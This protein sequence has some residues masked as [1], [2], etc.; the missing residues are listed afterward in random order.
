[1]WVAMAYRIP[2]EQ[3]IVKAIENVLVRTPHIRSQDELCRLVST[4]L[5]CMDEGYRVSGDRIRR[6]GINRGLFDLE[7]RYARTNRSGN[8]RECPVCGNSLR[9]VRNRTLEWGTVELTRVCDV[10]GYSAGGDAERP[11]RYIIT[12]RI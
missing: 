6:I 12:R 8:G 7:I 4:E 10:C 11:A 2:R 1:M 5:L 9:S 3:E